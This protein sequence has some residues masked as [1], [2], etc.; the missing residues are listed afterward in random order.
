MLEAQAA[1]TPDN[2]A[3][4]DRHRQLTYRQLNQQNNQLAAALS[5][6]G[7]GYGECVAL[8]LDRSV[9]LLV[10]IWAILKLGTVYLPVDP[11]F[12]YDRIDYI[13]QD[14]Q[15]G[16]VIF[17]RHIGSGWRRKGGT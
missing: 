16:V 5:G 13:L 12:P 14:S 8:C 9:E 1:L 10:S 11:V 2:I 17:I 4:K 6:L 7:V 3:C 15:A